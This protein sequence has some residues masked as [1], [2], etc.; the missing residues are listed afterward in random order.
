[1]KMEKQRYVA[2][3]NSTS[4]IIAPLS[5]NSDLI[6]GYSVAEHCQ[7]AAEGPLALAPNYHEEGQHFQTGIEICLT[8]SLFN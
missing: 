4:T 8:C 5:K 3:S 2:L 6:K 1:M 7:P